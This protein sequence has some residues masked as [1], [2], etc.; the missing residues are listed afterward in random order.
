MRAIELKNEIIPLNLEGPDFSSLVDIIQNKKVV[1]LGES[2]HGTQE[3]YNLRIQL[4]KHLIEHCG[5]NAV[6]IEG[7]WADAYRV[8]RFVKGKGSDHNAKSSLSSFDTYP[9]WL[10]RNKSVLDFIS[11][12]K[13]R[14]KISSLKTGF[15]GLDLYG[16]QR[17][18]S[19][20]LKRL[21]KYDKIEYAEAKKAYACFEFPLVRASDYGREVFHGLK[22]SC[23]NEA[24]YEL[25]RIRE[26]FLNSELNHSGK[27]LFFN[28]VQNA[29]TVVGAESY[30]RALFEP[31]MSS[32]NIR[33]KHMFDTLTSIEERI[34][35]EQNPKIVV[36]AHNS[37]VGRPAGEFI[38]TTREVT[39]GGLC[40]EYYKDMCFSVGM[41]TCTG[42]VT[43]SHGWDED[44]KIFDIN[45]PIPNSYE[46]LFGKVGS[47][48]MIPTETIKEL[49]FPMY[50]RAIGVIY[51]PEREKIGHY[52]ESDLAAR[53]DWMIHVEKSNPLHPL[54][55]LHLWHRV[56]KNKEKDLY[57]SSY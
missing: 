15:Y 49:K 38:N 55:D 21:K 48:F 19:I 3:F 6:A 39:L 14:N 30:Y 10:W 35:E 16:M 36:W 45:E 47:D 24:I 54:D 31:G 12:L 7:D 29:R 44:G 33:D 32:W 43:A 22:K 52:F 28:L 26:F 1:L 5:F 17:S 42:Q 56:L 4:T 20:I 34:G 51:Q 50:E 37:H 27:E 2:T 57:P 53:Y 9:L 25:E 46:E 11:W 18:V 8:N 40:A 23:S 41:S 13:N